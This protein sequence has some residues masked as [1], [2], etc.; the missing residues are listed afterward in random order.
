[1]FLNNDTDFMV[2]RERQKDLLREAERERL[3]RAVEKAAD[4]SHRPLR[5]AVAWTG[6]LLVRWGRA[7]QRY[8]VME[9]IQTLQVAK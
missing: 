1:M 7:L 5:Q 9:P 8:G 4:G 2:V 3:A 6:D